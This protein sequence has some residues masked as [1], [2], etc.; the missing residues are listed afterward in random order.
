MSKDIM[1]LGPVGSG[2]KSEAHQQ[3]FLRGGV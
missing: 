3:F 1:H 2:A